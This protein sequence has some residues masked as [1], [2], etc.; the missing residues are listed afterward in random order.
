MPTAASTAILVVTQNAS[1]TVN[2][3]SNAEYCVGTPFSQVLNAQN[4]GAT[5]DWN[6]G[7]ATTQTFTAT[8]AGTYTVRVT[9]PNGCAGYD[10]SNGHRE[11]VA[12]TEFG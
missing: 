3:G 2:L 7:A 12:R 6:N 8:T 4:A 1:P 9:N 10:T 5:Y 11:P